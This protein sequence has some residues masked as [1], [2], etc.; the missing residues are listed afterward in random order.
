MPSASFVAGACPPGRGR[1]GSPV[2]SDP[3]SPPFDADF[4]AGE[5]RHK[6]VQVRPELADTFGAKVAEPATA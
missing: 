2:S 1:R 3:P 4:P 5:A 6:P